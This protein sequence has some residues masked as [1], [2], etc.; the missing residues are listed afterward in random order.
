MLSVEGTPGSANNVRNRTKEIPMNQL[1]FE[2]I[3][4]DDTLTTMS[5][6]P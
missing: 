6:H 1:G 3:M 4:S 2:N 5:L